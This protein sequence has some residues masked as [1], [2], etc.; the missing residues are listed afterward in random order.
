MAT[1]MTQPVQRRSGIAASVMLT[2][3]IVAFAGCGKSSKVV[4]A[5][6]PAPGSAQANLEAI[7]EAYMSFMNKQG[8]APKDVDELK[9]SLM[10]YGDPEKLLVSP[11]DNLPFVIVFPSNGNMTAAGAVAPIMAYEKK[12]KDGKRYAINLSAYGLHLTD[13]ELKKSPFPPGYKAEF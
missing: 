1:S 10:T 5:P 11:E 9:P 3:A 8:R 13:D 2:F 12:G 6:G 4:E 7:Y